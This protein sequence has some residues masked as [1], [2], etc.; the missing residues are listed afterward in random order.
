MFALPARASGA[1]PCAMDLLHFGMRKPLRNAVHADDHAALH[2]VWRYCGAAPRRVLVL[3]SGK[4][5]D[6]SP[7]RHKR[8]AHHH[9]GPC[10]RAA[11]PRASRFNGEC[12]PEPLHE[13]FVTTS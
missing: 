9:F 2:H 10:V 1:P 13:H 11:A 7:P 4:P 6:Y 5:H 12:G 8:I 3:P